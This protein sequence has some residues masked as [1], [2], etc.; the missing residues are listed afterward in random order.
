MP[1]VSVQA[2]LAG[3][4]PVPST[5]Q[6]CKVRGFI[7]ETQATSAAY[8]LVAEM[9]EQPLAAKHVIELEQLPET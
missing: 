5:L 7:M 9:L 3:T 2:A 6:D 8:V 1:P 4:M